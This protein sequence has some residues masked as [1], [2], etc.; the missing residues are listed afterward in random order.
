MLYGA[1]LGLL[2]RFPEKDT[3]LVEARA[4]FKKENER[5]KYSYATYYMLCYGWEQQ[6]LK[7]NLVTSFDEESLIEDFYKNKLILSSDEKYLICE[8][9][10]RLR[11]AVRKNNTEDATKAHQE[12]Y[13]QLEDMK[14]TQDDNVRYYDVDTL[15]VSAFL[16][17]AEYLYEL[18]DNKNAKTVIE[19]A[20]AITKD[21]EYPR[22]SQLDKLAS[23]LS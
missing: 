3:N 22:R 12:L 20:L 1:V 14:Y 16:D 8:R 11:K 18:K 17:Y 19:Q 4:I 13:D 10:I 21:I 15:S 2:K 23:N 5:R 9:I 7:N 6:K